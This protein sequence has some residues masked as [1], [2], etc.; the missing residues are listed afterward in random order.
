MAG[1]G[2]VITGTLSDGSLHTGDEVEILPSGLHPRIRGLQT[3]KRK[4]DI[5]VPGSRTAVNLSG[6]NLDQ[7]KR[8]DVVT[9]PGSYHTSQRIDVRFRLLPDVISLS[10]HPGQILYR[11]SR[12]NQVRLLGAMSSPGGGCNSSSR[13]R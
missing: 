3:H 5:A 2:T 9:Y 6:I 13:R 10:Q 4:E 7:V 8:G 12:N 1:F 11:R